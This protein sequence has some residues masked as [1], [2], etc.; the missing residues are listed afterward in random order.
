[1]G[2]ETMT[3]TYEAAVDSAKRQRANEPHCTCTV[4][5][6]AAALLA[7]DEV[8]KLAQHEA[9]IHNG[10]AELTAALTALRGMR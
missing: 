4:C 3:S 7:A 8:V 5:C 9:N 1:M 6:Y 10:P 2:N